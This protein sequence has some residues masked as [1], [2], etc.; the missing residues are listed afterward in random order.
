MALVSAA[1]CEDPVL[2][3]PC[4]PTEAKAGHCTLE[5]D[6]GAG[7]AGDAGDGGGGAGGDGG[8]GSAS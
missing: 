7:D 2:Y 5:S 4:T 1:G 6:A 3:G 8:G